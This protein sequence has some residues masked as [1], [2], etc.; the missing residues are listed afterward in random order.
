M[1]SQLQMTGSSAA[2]LSFE[3]YHE[4][5]ALLKEVPDGSTEFCEFP[6][7]VISSAIRSVEELTKARVKEFVFHDL[8]KGLDGKSKS[9]RV[10]A[11]EEILL[12]HPDKFNLLPKARARDRDQVEEAAGIVARILTNLL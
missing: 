6:W 9:E 3:I 10:R 1:R 4:K 11:R 5:W 12:W 2:E 8:R 7:P